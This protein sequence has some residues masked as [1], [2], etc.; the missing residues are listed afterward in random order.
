MSK[1]ITYVCVASSIVA[2][3]SPSSIG[4]PPHWI[5]F[6][7]IGLDNAQQSPSIDNGVPSS[8]KIISPSYA[9]PQI[10]QTPVP[11]SSKLN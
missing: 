9:N 3:T 1:V 4:S 5:R 10:R 11:A 6:T 7:S 8:P 2:V